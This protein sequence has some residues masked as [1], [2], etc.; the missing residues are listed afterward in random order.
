MEEATEAAPGGSMSE[1]ELDL[2]HTVTR[3]HGVDRHGDLHSVAGRE[4]QHC[5]QRLMAERPLPGS[6]ERTPTEP[7]GPWPFSGMAATI[8][9][10]SF[11]G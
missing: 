7:A 5:A 6:D 4:R 11:R 9:C 10:A 8:L 3:A 1:V 2:L